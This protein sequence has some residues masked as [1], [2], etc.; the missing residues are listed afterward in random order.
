MI[1]GFG[2]DSSKT[3][4]IGSIR[5]TR[6]ILWLAR[7]MDPHGCVLDRVLL[8]AFDHL[9]QNV[10]PGGLRWR[11][12]IA[13]P[14]VYLLRFA[15]VEMNLLAAGRMFAEFRDD[16]IVARLLRAKLGSSLRV[17]RFPRHF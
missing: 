13:E 3:L 17:S 15:G 12:W 4:P 5:L 6:K 10:S 16:R 8:T 2:T 14:D 7:R 11:C 9:N 1:P